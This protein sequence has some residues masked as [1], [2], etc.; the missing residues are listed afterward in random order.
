MSQAA[1]THALLD[2]D[3]S[4]PE[5]LS[6]GFGAPAGR[7]FSVYRNNVTV[8]LIDAM[9]AGFPAVV[10][11]LGEENFR[12]IA[13]EYARAHPP[14]SPLMVLY[15][16]DFADFLAGFAPLE[17]YGYLPDVAR[18]EY[19]LRESYHAADAAPVAPDR[20]AELPPETLA[21]ARLTLAPTLRL[22]CSPWPALSIWRFNMQDGAPKPEAAAEDVLIARK[23]YDPAPH[24]L[25]PGA[26]AFIAACQ[27]GARLR[28]AAEAAGE[29][30][31]LGAVLGLLLE[32][33]SIVDVL[34][35]NSP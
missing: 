27:Q 20:L 12:N 30:L 6:D 2:P 5:G 33:G 29:G 31:D 10:K 3:R 17:R 23:E 14:Q 15:G 7:R 28:E 16:A 21:E 9:A 32:T 35:E 22:L 24:L 25:G 1:F 26:A 11:L 4:E 8:A 18:L 19:A 13:R 34:H